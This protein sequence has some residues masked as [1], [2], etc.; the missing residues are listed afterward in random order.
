MSLSQTTASA[1]SRQPQATDSH[2]PSVL[3]NGEIWY[4]SWPWRMPTQAHRRM[5]ARSGTGMPESKGLEGAKGW[6]AL[7]APKG[8]FDA[9]TGRFGWSNHRSTYPR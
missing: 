2:L 8:N 4:W 9:G 7:E 6:T 3:R 5:G 1:I